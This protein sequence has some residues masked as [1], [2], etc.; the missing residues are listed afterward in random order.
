MAGYTSLVDG[1]TGLVQRTKINTQFSELFGENTK[2][3]ITV[4]D[5]AALAAIPAEYIATGKRALQLDTKTWYRWSGAAWVVETDL[6]V[7]YETVLVGA[8]AILADFPTAKVIASEGNTGHTYAG[9]LGITGEATSDGTATSTGVGGNA[10]ANGAFDGRG[11]VGVGKVTASADTGDSIGLFARAIDTHAGGR[12]I[13]VFSRALNGASNYSFYGAKGVLYNDEAIETPKVMLTP[14]GGIATLMTAGE[15]LAAGEVVSVL[16][17]PSGADNTVHKTPISGNSNDMPM[18]V[19]YAAA[20]TGNDVWIVVSGVAD[21]LPTAAVTAARGYVMTA[22]TTTA[23]RVD[24]AAAVPVAATHFKECGHFI[25]T[26][27]GAGAKT[28]AIIH[29]N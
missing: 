22:S 20:T 19:V 7:K 29:F 16:Q 6:A 24:Q 27:S 5:A 13:G 14:E 23:G 18:G 11:V 8:D 4:A 1:A 9:A 15:N 28:R 12:N 17:S 2:A 26:G 21:V 3:A 10:T 25:A